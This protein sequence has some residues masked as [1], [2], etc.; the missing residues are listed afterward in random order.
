METSTIEQTDQSIET[1]ITNIDQANEQAPLSQLEL[2]MVSAKDALG[3]DEAPSESLKRETEKSLKNVPEDKLAPKRHPD[4]KFKSKDNAPVKAGKKEAT[5]SAPPTA[6]EPKLAPAP[7]TPQKV[8]IGDKEYSISELEKALNERQAAAQR[9]PEPQKAATAAEPQKQPTPEEISAMEMQFVNEFSKSVG[10]IPVNEEQLEKILIGGKEG[11]SALVDLL[12]TTSARATLEARKSIYAELNP[13]VQ[14]IVSQLTPLVENNAQI[15]RFTVENMFTTQFPEYQGELLGTA[16]MVAEELVKQYP[17]IT[18]QYTREQFIAEV[19]RQS[20]RII[21]EEFKRWN[22]NFQGTWKDYAKMQ[23]AAQPAATP[24]P[25]PPSV[26]AKPA[27]PVSKP[28]TPV[29]SKPAVKA[30]AA[31]SP[32]NMTGGSIKEWGKSVAGTLVD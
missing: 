7:E 32:H 5:I 15:E 23:K 29:S 1:G 27:A 26:A 25:V 10:E 18:S 28:A 2:P 4:G 24:A 20:S 9:Q 31:N 17:Q 13:H 3:L 16:K 12:K 11:V 19:D 21:G 8:K 22:P 14:T 30:P 6:P